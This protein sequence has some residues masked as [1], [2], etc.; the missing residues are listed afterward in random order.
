MKT[1]VALAVLFGMGLFITGCNTVE[2]AGKDTK[3]AGQS[4][5]NAADRNK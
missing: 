5:E 4:I 1:I 2:G 3:N